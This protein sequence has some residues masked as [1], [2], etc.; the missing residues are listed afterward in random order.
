MVEKLKRKKMTGY[1]LFIKVPELLL[2]TEERV[3]KLNG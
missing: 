2:R 3:E 1:S